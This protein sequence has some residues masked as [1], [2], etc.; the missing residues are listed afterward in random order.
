MSI[1]ATKSY[2]LKLRIEVVLNVNGPHSGRNH[3]Y[4]SVQDKL[5]AMLIGIATRQMQSCSR[6]ET[7]GSTNSNLQFALQ[8]N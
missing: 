1:E 3:R 2:L 8:C 4:W 5:L 7:D 6:C